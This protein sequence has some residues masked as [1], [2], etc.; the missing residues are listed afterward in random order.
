MEPERKTMGLPESPADKIARL[1]KENAALSAKLG[2][3]TETIAQ[4]EAQVAAQVQYGTSVTEIAC[5]TR[6]V[7]K[8]DSDGDVV[9]RRVRKLDGEG[10]PED[11]EDGKPMFVKEAMYDE[12]P[13]FR[14][15]I[16]IPPSGGLALVINSVHY[17]DGEV[18]EFTI[19]ELRTI[20]DMVARSWSH[21]AS[22][23]GQQN[24]NAYRRPS[25]YTING[26]TG[27]ISR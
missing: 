16:D 8:R 4:K 9:T 22:I 18:Y 27:H 13:I 12:V 7:K 19:E 25:P 26:R 1:E 21:E 3:A 24:E 6:R 14:Y 15:K 11:D 17:Y 10:Q 20:K 5:G 2:E 23:Q